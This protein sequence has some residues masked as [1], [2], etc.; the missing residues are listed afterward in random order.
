MAAD[1]RRLPVEGLANDA[2][3]ETLFEG[4]HKR[5]FLAFPAH[6]GGPRG[7]HEMELPRAY[8]MR[9]FAI[10]FRQPAGKLDRG[11]LMRQE[12]E[13]RRGELGSIA[14]WN[15]KAAGDHSAVS[16][17]RSSDCEGSRDVRREIDQGC[18]GHVKKRPAAGRRRL[19]LDSTRRRRSANEL[20][21]DEMLPTDHGPSVTKSLNFPLQQF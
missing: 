1:F 11:P 17:P 5:L 15:S 7:G 6:G 18:L 13:L 3:E 8:A 21:A 10:A 4:D 14:P 16:A 19:R 12:G 2:R 9:L 20:Y